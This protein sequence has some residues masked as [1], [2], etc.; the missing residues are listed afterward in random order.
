VIDPVSDE[1]E[2]RAAL[3]WPWRSALLAALLVHVATAGAVLL[4]SRTHR[5]PLLLP[6][7]QVR[8]GVVAPAPAGPAARPGSPRSAAAV[9]P[10]PARPAP[11]PAA[12]TAPPAAGTAP[13]S[14][15]TAPKSAAPTAPPAPPAAGAGAEPAAGGAGAEPA[16]GG[17]EAGTAAPGAGSLAVL[18]GDGGGGEP[19][20]FDYYL[21]RLLGAIEAN[22]FR[23]PAP[24]GTR[25]RVLC[26]IDRDGR[27]LESGI[28]APSAVPAFDRAALRAIYAAAPFPPLPQGFSGATLTLHLDFG[29]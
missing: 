21:Q 26:R 12:K 1:L 3:T 2:R 23:P 28:E 20:P 29:P 6:S 10:A 7:V 17:A 9:Q 14:R 19:F 5:R 18:T 22:W 13:A 25:C 11:R 24:D 27:L 16:A 8:L 4:A 15:R